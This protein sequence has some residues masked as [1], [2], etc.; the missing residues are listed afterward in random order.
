MSTANCFSPSDS[1][2]SIEKPQGCVVE[3]HTAT[4]KIPQKDKGKRFWNSFCTVIRTQRIR[5]HLH[6][7]STTETAFHVTTAPVSAI[8]AS[9]LIR[10]HWSIENKW[11]WLRDIG[12][13]EDS[14]QATGFTA[15]GLA[16]LRT[17]TINMAHNRKT[18]I[19]K[20]QREIWRDFKS[21]ANWIKK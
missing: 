7:K 14:C 17:W 20:T 5:H 21:L 4:W 2:S 19:T 8:F 13:H 11:H 6:K 15:R 12:F 10:S 9:K 1:H 18:S 16:T 3:R